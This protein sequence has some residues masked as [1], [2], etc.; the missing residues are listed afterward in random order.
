[1]LGLPDSVRA[2]PFDLDGVPRRDGAVVV[3]GD[4]GELLERR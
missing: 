3:V 2:S 4:L 1:M